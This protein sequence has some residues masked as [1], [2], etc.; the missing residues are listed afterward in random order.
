[1]SLWWL[2]VKNMVAAITEFLSLF[3]SVIINIYIQQHVFYLPEL[4]VTFITLYFFSTFFDSYY[5]SGFQYQ[6]TLKVFINLK[7]SIITLWIDS[8]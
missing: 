7:L 6:L 2:S 1:M 5:I 3:D 8:D 4:K